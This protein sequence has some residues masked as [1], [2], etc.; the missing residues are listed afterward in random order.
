MIKASY[1]MQTRNRL[2]LSVCPTFFFFSVLPPPPPPPLYNSNI[3]AQ[4]VL[5]LDSAKIVSQHEGLTFQRV[6]RFSEERMITSQC[7]FHKSRCGCNVGGN[8]SLSRSDVDGHIVILL[9]N[10]KFFFLCHIA[11][12]L[13]ISQCFLHYGNCVL[14]I[15]S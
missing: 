8:G 3:R 6:N 2:P 1:L 11:M 7:G 10:R 4:K 13:V 15:T 14:S 12:L 9:E 5:E